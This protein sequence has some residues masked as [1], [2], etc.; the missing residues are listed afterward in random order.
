MFI[1]DSRKIEQEIG[2][3]PKKTV[4]NVFED[5]FEWIKENEQQLKNI[6]K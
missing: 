1:A 4:Q 2:W 3:K 6:L 5:V